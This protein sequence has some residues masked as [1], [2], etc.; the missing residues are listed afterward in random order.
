[1]VIGMTEKQ[2]EIIADN[3]RAYKVNFGYIKIE[4]EDYGKG[5]YVFISEEKAKQG[6]W[7]QYCYNIDYLNGWLYG[8]VQGAMGCVKFT[9]ERKRELND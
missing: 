7:T 8:C 5:F 3:L 4:K 1:M 9:E 2:K 6:S